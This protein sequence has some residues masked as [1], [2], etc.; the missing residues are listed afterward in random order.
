MRRLKSVTLS[1]DHVLCSGHES[2]CL[3]PGLLCL[4]HVQVHFIAIEV[5]VVGAA[6]TLVESERAERHHF[7]SVTNKAPD[8]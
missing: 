3:C 1:T 7:G 4:R 5:S 2:E 8:L 6:H